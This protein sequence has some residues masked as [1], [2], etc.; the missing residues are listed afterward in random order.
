VPAPPEVS[1]REPGSDFDIDVDR[2]VGHE[3]LLDET[4]WI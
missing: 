3:F 4:N 2:A 1:E